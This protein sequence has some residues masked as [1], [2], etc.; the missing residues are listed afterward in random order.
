MTFEQLTCLSCGLTGP[1]FAKAH[2]SFS[3]TIL[4]DYLDLSDVWGAG[5]IKKPGKRWS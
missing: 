4:M 5:T 2:G 3:L 1:T